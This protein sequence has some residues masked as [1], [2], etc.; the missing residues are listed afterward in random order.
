MLPVFGKLDVFVDPHN[1][2]PCRWIE[3]VSKE[4]E[5]DI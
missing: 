2:K 4:K 1:I 3:S 5:S